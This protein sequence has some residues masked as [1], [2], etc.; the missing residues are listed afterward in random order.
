MIGLVHPALRLTTEVESV[1]LG[2]VPDAAVR[3]RRRSFRESSQ[4][5]GRGFRRSASAGGEQVG[6]P[7]SRAMRRPAASADPEQA[8]PV[9]AVAKVEGRPAWRCQFVER[10]QAVLLEVAVV[11]QVGATLYVER[12]VP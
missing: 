5:R 3:H 7:A 8:A 4:E 1:G 11:R 12:Q 6:S 2:A 9:V 10:L